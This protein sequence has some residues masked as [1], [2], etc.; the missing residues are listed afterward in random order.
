MAKNKYSDEFKNK[1]ISEYK[2]GKS[3]SQL[4]KEYNL[5]Y[6]TMNHW[7]NNENSIDVGNVKYSDEIVD[8]VL[9]D[10]MSGDS[11]VTIAQRYKIKT[12]TVYSWIKK[13][14]VS[15]QKGP[16]SLCKNYTYFDNIDTE[17]KAYFLGY[18]IAD[19]NVSI[20][21]GQYAFKITLQYQDRYIIEKLVNELEAENHIRNF[22]QKSPTSDNVNQYSYVSIGN[23]HLVKSL[24]N[25]G[26]IP[27]KT[28]HETLPNIR[29]DLVRHMVR[30]FFD[31]DGIA[32]K[33]EKTYC[34]GFIGNKQILTQLENILKWG[35]VFNPHVITN[36]IYTVFTS[37][38]KKLTDFYHYMYDDSSLFLQRK[39]DKLKVIIDS[40]VHGQDPQ[41]TMD[42]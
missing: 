25:L 17:M 21:K 32:C 31:G 26:I 5:S 23:K 36:G 42:D 9:R 18:I 16:I 29:P 6:N 27:A 4:K 39:H 38:K 12:G 40:A 28:F 30:G 11:A 1:I 20:C 34:F 7:I 19:G 3:K 2:N 14:G 33:T 35:N 22:W 13:A 37:D 8:I 24:M 10:Y 41:E 15:R